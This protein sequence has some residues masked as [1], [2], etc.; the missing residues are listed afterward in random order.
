MKCEMYFPE[1]M[2]EGG[3]ARLWMFDKAPLGVSGV[4]FDKKTIPEGRDRTLAPC[5]RRAVPT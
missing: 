4:L 1:R 3:K 2:V 5:E